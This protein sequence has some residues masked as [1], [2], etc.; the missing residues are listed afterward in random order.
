MDRD[1]LLNDPQTAMRLMLDGRQA[2]IWTQL[3]GIITA[4][5]YDAM[6]CEVQ[7]AIQGTV[8]DEN[9]VK[10]FVNLPVLVDV[11]I[12]FPRAG[13]FIVTLPLEAGDE[14]LV[15]ISSRCID[16]WWQNGG[17]QMPMEARMHDLSDGFAIPGP[18]SQQMLP[19]GGFSDTRVEIR[20]DAGNVYLAM[21]MK[22]AMVNASTDLKT[23]LSDLTSAI[24]SFM[25]TLAA[26]TPP[27]TPVINSVLTL[28]AS[29]AVTALGA[30]TT[31]INALLEST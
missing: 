17:V 26:L 20:D 21:G 29:T 25:Q 19:D 13:G 8:T 28:P 31:K 30:V 1:E 24:N 5:D 15:S 12:V 10:Q 3:P 27:T 6:T 22:F 4:V 23:L 16:A 18:C 11:P 14:V 7:P 9:G 2:N